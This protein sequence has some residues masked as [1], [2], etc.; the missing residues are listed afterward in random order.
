MAKQETAKLYLLALR[1]FPLVE[2]PVLLL[3]IGRASQDSDPL[4]TLLLRH[5]QLVNVPF[6][7][8]G[9]QEISLHGGS[10][11][12]LNE[13]DGWQAVRGEGAQEGGNMVTL[14]QICE[15]VWLKTCHL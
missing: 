4:L 7:V 9:S 11:L 2:G 5:S 15:N 13:T 10:F 3:A 12:T 6:H 14:G 1:P 8:P